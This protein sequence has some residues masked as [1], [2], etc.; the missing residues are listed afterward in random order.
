[1]ATFCSTCGTPLVPNSKFCE[2]CGTPAPTQVL[3]PPSQR[4][5]VIAEQAMAI[6]PAQ[7]A[8]FV[9][10]SC[11]GDP[12]LI[13][14]VQSLLPPDTMQQVPRTGPSGIVGMTP[15]GTPIYD[16]P[17]SAMFGTG[18]S[19]SAMG[20]STP[21]GP[22]SFIGAYRVVRELGR[23]GMGV[24]YLA[25]RD[26][27]AF[28]KNVAL[29]LLL[30]DQVTDE[31]ILRFRQERQVL[32]AMDHP[33]IARILDG[34]DTQDGM[35]YY[36]MEYVEGV[37]LDQYC[38]QQRLSL[39]GRLHL[40][41]GVCQ[42][43]NY[44]HQNAIV[45]RDLKPSNILVSKDGQVKLLDFGI[46]KMVGAAS[47]VT[48]ELTTAQ[49]GP[50]TPTYASPEQIAGA[51]LTSTSDIYSLGAILYNLLTGRSAYNGIDDKL[52]KIAAGQ[53]P[54][55]PSANIREDLKSSE[56]TQQLRRAM[57]GELDDIVLMS[58]RFDPRERYQSAADFANDV[59]AFMDG[60]PVVAHQVSAAARS[61]RLLKRKRAVV[62][63][64]V[65]FVGLASFAGWEAYR[66]QAQKSVA[67]AREMELRTLLDQLEAKL[68]PLQ[69]A[70]GQPETRPVTE[71]IADIA[72]L[73][74]AFDKTYAAMIGAKPEANPDRDALLARG[75]KYLDRVQ[76]QQSDP[77][78]GFE[79]AG[80]YQQFGLLQEN[81]AAV[82]QAAVDTYK[83]SS[84]V[85]TSICLANPGNT[86]AQE[87]LA[88]VNQKLKSLGAE[89]P[90]QLTSEPPPQQVTP[91]PAPVVQTPEPKPAPRKEEPKP[92]PVVTQAPP[93]VQP[94][95]AEP[96]V[97]AKPAIDPA[98]MAEVQ[99]RLISV[100]A[101]VSGAEQQIGQ[102]RANLQRA[103]QA[104]NPDTEANVSRMR[105][106]LDRAKRDLAG[107]NLAAAKEDLDASDAYASRVMRVLGR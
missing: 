65:A 26:D 15:S 49:R 7:R 45:H 89:P 35:P 50:M 91:E 43:V 22:G 101:K 4:A 55:A 97:A 32:A 105:A 93:P 61:L 85:L 77:N 58:L 88:V 96:V 6:H 54:T 46:A 82:K 19:P 106:S 66:I 76:A 25:M 98:E 74:T 31:F 44:L 48:P 41:Q 70:N 80:A 79:V 90:R 23:G 2:K 69:T 9:Q 81:T 72:R 18:V 59:Q 103:G 73:R 95:P 36:V 83:K 1:M 47:V 78:L 10:T 37:P 30:R 14:E 17:A 11:G 12:A 53:P 99:D 20:Y 40:F 64:V 27:G 24:V 104:L 57:M 102:L 87:R 68:G 86:A 34:G 107:G 100:T 62:A 52:A 71:F 8:Q 75:V 3:T 16:S 84:G 29:K 13:Q 33:N 60:R 5:R 94:R 28:R 67:V 42:A 38:D 39:T 21:I 63:A 51:T 92:A 56:T